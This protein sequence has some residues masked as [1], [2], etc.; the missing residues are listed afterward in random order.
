[1]WCKV[2]VVDTKQFC[3]C[4]LSVQCNMKQYVCFCVQQ[5]MVFCVVIS[6]AVL[7]CTHSLTRSLVVFRNK[8]AF[9]F[10]LHVLYISHAAFF[11]FCMIQKFYIIYIDFMYEQ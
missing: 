11:S 7:N 3:C 4:I 2:I 8:F 9:H 6:S 5:L 1:M 10:I